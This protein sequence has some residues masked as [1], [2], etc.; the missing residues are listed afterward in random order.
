MAFTSDYKFRGKH[1]TYVKFLSKNRGELRENGVNVFNRILDV[2]LLAPIIGL[3]YNKRGVVDHD[4]NDTSTIFY[5]QIEQEK[6]ALDYVYRMVIMCDVNTD[7]DYIGR[8]EQAFKYDNDSIQT[9][10]NDR[11]FNSY[12]LGGVE[13]LYDLFKAD[14]GDEEA[15]FEHILELVNEFDSNE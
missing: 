3:Y 13:Y 8:V 12:V 7:K 14:V 1:A 2:Y 10:N 11:V 9:E 4:S 5:A 6:P 15:I